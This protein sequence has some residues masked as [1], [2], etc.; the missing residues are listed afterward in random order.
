[1]LGD[2]YMICELI[3]KHKYGEAQIRIQQEQEQFRR[4]EV[5][6]RHRQIDTLIQSILQ[7]DRQI[8]LITQQMANL[9]EH[10]T[11]ELYERLTQFLIELKMERTR[12]LV[13]KRK[14]SKV[15]YL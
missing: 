3:R 10:D 13:E 11:K 1:M 8:H 6:E 15:K 12:L 5:C 14:T 4:L 7:I 2:I 9:A